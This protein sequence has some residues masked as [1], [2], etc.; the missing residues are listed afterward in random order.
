MP[1]EEP[2]EKRG[3]RQVNHRTAHSLFDENEAAMLRRH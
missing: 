1:K 3:Y 2:A